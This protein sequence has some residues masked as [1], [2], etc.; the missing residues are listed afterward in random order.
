[1]EACAILS[2]RQ[3]IFHPVLYLH[4]ILTR[5]PLA[6]HPRLN[7]RWFHELLPLAEKFDIVI[8]LE[9][10]FDYRHLQQPGDA[11]VP[12]TTAQDMLELVYGIGSNRVQLCLDTGH[13]PISGRTPDDPR[14]A[15]PRCI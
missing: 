2:C 5:K 8:N 10:T 9:N 4:R 3:L 12:Y 15:P 13:M 1:M 14:R 7:V 11:P 6:A